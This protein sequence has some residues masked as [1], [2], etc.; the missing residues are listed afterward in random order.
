[1]DAWSSKRIA[2]TIL[3][4]MVLTSIMNFQVS[5]D[6]HF[7]S[8]VSSAMLKIFNPPSFDGTR[9]TDDNDWLSNKL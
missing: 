2:L 7:G 6:K 4:D 9:V 5:S 3:G 1:V 8:D